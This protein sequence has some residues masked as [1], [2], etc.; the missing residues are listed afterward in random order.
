M[1]SVRV[2]DQVLRVWE[3]LGDR[4][5]NQPC[6]PG[7]SAKERTSHGRGVWEALGSSIIR[8][9]RVWEALG[10]CFICVLHDFV[11]SDVVLS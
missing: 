6:I 11:L 1:L 2:L 5:S 4:M 9:L 8:I 10:T 3:A 7:G